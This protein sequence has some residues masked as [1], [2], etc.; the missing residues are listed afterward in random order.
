MNEFGETGEEYNDEWYNIEIDDILTPIE[1]GGYALVE[2]FECTDY[3]EDPEG[4]IKGVEEA[5]QHLNTALNDL[6][7]YHAE[8]EQAAV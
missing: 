4:Y 3:E 1:N 7:E 2:A 5:L 8:Y 6:R